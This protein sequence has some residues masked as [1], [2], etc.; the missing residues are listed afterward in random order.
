V[1]ARC[2]LPRSWEA[3]PPDEEMPQ[4]PEARARPKQ[5]RG[6][7]IRV[8]S[9]D[10]KE[11]TCII[12]GAGTR[13]ANDVRRALLSRVSTMAVDAVEIDINTSGA[14]DEELAQRLSLVP[15]TSASADVFSR[16]GECRRCSATASSLG[17]RVRCSECS[18]ELSLRVSVPSTDELSVLVTSND[19]HSADPRVSPLEGA[20]VVL[21]RLKPGQELHLVAVARRG[22]GSAHAKW[23]C[24]T[25]AVVSQD[26]KAKGAGESSLSLWF[27]C[28]GTV[29][30]SQ[31]LASALRELGCGTLLEVETSR[32]DDGASEPERLLRLT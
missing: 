25:A 30:P 5:R 23:S 14:L 22:T 8:T 16:E 31:V 24:V 27:E 11:L 3:T 19:L 9:S 32:D 12:L 10:D 28:I 1:T 6:A 18:V 29:P 2:R 15:L 13:A 4:S 7:S 17:S 26:A 20:S 21:A